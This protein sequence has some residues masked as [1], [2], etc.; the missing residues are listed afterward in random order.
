MNNSS[1][2][3]D[4]HIYLETTNI[5]LFDSENNLRKFWENSE[6]ILRKHE[7]SKFLPYREL[8]FRFS[9]ILTGVSEFLWSE[10]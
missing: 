8:E 4:M 1:N 5:I 6:K 2:T 7:K 10:L 9:G 3:P